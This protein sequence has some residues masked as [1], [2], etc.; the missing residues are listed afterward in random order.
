MVFLL[1]LEYLVIR[2]FTTFS[3]LKLLNICYI[4]LFYI[5][6]SYYNLKYCFLCHCV[7]V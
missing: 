6:S 5:F 3:L 7:R 2:H 1:L 4:I